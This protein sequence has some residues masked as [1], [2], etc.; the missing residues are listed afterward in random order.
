MSECFKLNICKF[1]LYVLF[2]GSVIY[3]IL[4]VDI[5]LSVEIK[6]QRADVA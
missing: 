5:D 6:A 1:V 2:A 4:L 3:F